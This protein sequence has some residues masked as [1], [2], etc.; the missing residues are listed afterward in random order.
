MLMQQES[1]PN[2]VDMASLVTKLSK[3]SP[4]KQPIN[5]RSTTANN[6]PMFH[7]NVFRNGRQPT[8]DTLHSAISQQ[9]A[10]RN[11]YQNTDKATFQQQQQPEVEVQVVRR[12]VK[13]DKKFDCRQ[14]PDGVYGGG[15]RSFVRCQG[16]MTLNVDCR[17]PHV[18]N[19][20]TGNCDR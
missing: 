3:L 8:Y 6:N 4:V 20:H 15:C 10:K 18:F 19:K 7:Q 12:R 14:L 5:F 16:G 2:T 9:N 13:S 11:L 1:S 17:S